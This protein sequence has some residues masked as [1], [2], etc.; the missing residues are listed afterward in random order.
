MKWVVGA[1]AIVLSLSIGIPARAGGQRG[2]GPNRPVPPARPSM[3]PPTAPAVPTPVG[4]VGQTAPRFVSR[5]TLRPWRYGLGTRQYPY[6]GYFGYPVAYGSGGFGSFP[7]DQSVPPEVPG[8][9]PPAPYPPQMAVPSVD[10][11]PTTRLEPGPSSIQPSETL[12]QPLPP[13]P[14]VGGNIRFQAL[15]DFARIYVDGFYVGTVADANRFPEGMSLRPGW[16][17]IE[18]RAPGYDTLA[19]NATIQSNRTIVYDGGMWTARQ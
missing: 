19:I 4:T 9:A 17:R 5:V 12:P 15:P 8:Q 3:R 11:A 1:C 10:L 7:Y 6:A 13:R 14:E 2:G 18:F 16:H